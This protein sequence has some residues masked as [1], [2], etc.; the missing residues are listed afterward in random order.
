[1]L[2]PTII[3]NLYVCSMSS[4]PKSSVSS[5]RQSDAN[6]RVQ[7]VSFLVELLTFAQQNGH[8]W[9]LEEYLLAV[10]HSLLERVSSE[11]RNNALLVFGFL[12]CASVMGYVLV[13]RTSHSAS[14][15][16]DTSSTA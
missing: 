3:Y 7:V 16:R 10:L 2:Q 8:T 12:L 1:M 13:C 14:R 15:V 6:V 4:H 11:A 5:Y 9:L